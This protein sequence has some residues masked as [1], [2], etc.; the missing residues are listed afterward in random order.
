[1]RDTDIDSDLGIYVYYNLE[2]N[3]ITLNTKA[4]DA[5]SKENDITKL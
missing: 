3:V 1:M 2:V 5:E 4:N